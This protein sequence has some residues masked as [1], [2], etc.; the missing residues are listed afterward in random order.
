MQILVQ[1]QAFGSWLAARRV[2]GQE[3]A[4]DPGAQARGRQR[5]GNAAECCAVVHLPAEK[6]E[7]PYVLERILGRLKYM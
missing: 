5:V 1:A 7:V 3:E 4:E 6:A 2:S